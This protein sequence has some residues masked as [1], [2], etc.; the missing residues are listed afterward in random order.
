VL[1]VYTLK[2]DEKGVENVS[3]EKIS[4]RKEAPAP[5]S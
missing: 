2:T 1:Y 4:F 3:V 5:A